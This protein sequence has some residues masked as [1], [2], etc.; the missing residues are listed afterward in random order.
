[1]YCTITTTN[2]C[3]N[4]SLYCTITTT[5]SCWNLSLYCT[6]T[7]TNSCW[8]LS[9]YCTIT[10]TNSCWNLSLYC[11]ITTTNSCWN[12][13][14]YCTI[15]TTN[16]CWNLSL[17]CTI[18]DSTPVSQSRHTLRFQPIACRSIIRRP[19]VL[20]TRPEMV[21]HA[22][23][24]VVRWQC[25]TWQKP[26]KRHRTKKRKKKRQLCR[27]DLCVSFPSPKHD[28]DRSSGTRS[29]V[30]LHLAASSFRVACQTPKKGQSLCCVVVY[31][32]PKDVQLPHWTN[33]SRFT[34]QN[35]LLPFSQ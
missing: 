13:S 19:R 31:Y 20:R 35:C 2:S 16:S 28:S 18:D 22:F 11:T 25:S 26:G 8:N 17:Y 33:S 14:L 5:N 32:N 15:T 10:T 21:W 27:F 6:I 12:L 30:L 9:L 4:L 34:C 23:V 7:T 1:M 24:L 29:R 3:W